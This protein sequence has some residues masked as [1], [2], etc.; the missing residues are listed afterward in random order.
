M[1]SQRS[2]KELLGLAFKLAVQAHG[3]KVDSLYGRPCIEHVVRVAGCFNSDKKMMV[4]LLHDALEDGGLSCFQL[5][6]CEFPQDVID[7]LLAISR[8]IGE[9]YFEYIERCKSNELA[10]QVK[11][12]DLNDRVYDEDFPPTKYLDSRYRKAIKILTA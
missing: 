5:E 11:I 3:N 10:R 1:K 6:R 7:A 4:A 8:Q 2:N 9:T 12:A